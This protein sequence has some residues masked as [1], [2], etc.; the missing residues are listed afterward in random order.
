M[1]LIGAY[2][3][4]YGAVTRKRKSVPKKIAYSR[5]FKKLMPLANLRTGGFSNL[6][7]NELKFHDTYVTG[8]TLGQTVAASIQ[9][10]NTGST[11]INGVIQ[12]T[13][14][15]ERIGRKCRFTSLQMRGSVL[16]EAASSASAPLVPGY[17]RILVV[18]DKQAN[19]ASLAEEEVLIQRSVGLAADSLRN[20]EHISRYTILADFI[21]R[22][23][24]Y[25]G[26]GTGSTQNWIAQQ[27]SFQKNIK[28][29]ITTLYDGTPGTI[30]EITD[31]AI[32]CMTIYQGSTGA[33]FNS[34]F[35]VRFY[36]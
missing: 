22:Q 18:H 36:T 17:V 29:N 34:N 16:F 4:R 2:G 9:T 3:G 11:A 25:N 26:T 28:L 12:G 21:V 8:S 10:L 20:M 15:S 14:E 33:Q 32:E 35:R 13:G 30:T 27:V 5:A 1:V 31:N 7:R 19:K 24:L 23:T 6:G